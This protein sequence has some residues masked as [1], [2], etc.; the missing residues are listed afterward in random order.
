MP[1]L[2][3]QI[4]GECQ[5]LLLNFEALLNKEYSDQYSLNGSLAVSLQF[6]TITPEGKARA[7]RHLQSKN[8]PSVV[9]YV[10]RFRSGFSSRY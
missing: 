6:S 3:D 10:R 4:F 7:L 8:Y 5:A 2:D 9:E 1:Q